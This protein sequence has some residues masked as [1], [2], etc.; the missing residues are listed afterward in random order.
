VVAALCKLLQ[1]N[2]GDA[3]LPLSAE[4]RL[5]TAFHNAL[6]HYQEFSAGVEVD[7]LAIVG[8]ISSS[9]CIWAPASPVAAVASATALRN[10]SASILSGS[11]SSHDLGCTAGFVE[12][13]ISTAQDIHNDMNGLYRI[14]GPEA[15]GSIRV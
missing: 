7:R 9:P 4:T 14:F 11:S 6:D 10:L 8:V 15:N 12:R 2:D 1:L 13:S 5:L 3:S